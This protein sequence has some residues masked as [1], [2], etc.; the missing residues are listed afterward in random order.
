MAVCW[1]MAIITVVAEHQWAVKPSSSVLEVVHGGWEGT[2][3][4]SSCMHTMCNTKCSWPHNALH[5]LSQIR[6][7]G[8]DSVGPKPRRQPLPPPPP[9][10]PNFSHH[11]ARVQAVGWFPLGTRK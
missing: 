2:T 7:G 3:Q 5:Q 9:V 8:G 1:M 4:S 11:K 6:G 10:G